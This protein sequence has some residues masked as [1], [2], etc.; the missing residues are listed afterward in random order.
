MTLFDVLS[1][2][3]GWQ[4]PEVMAMRFSNETPSYDGNESMSEASPYEAT[5]SARTSRSVDI[6]SLGCIF[7]CT[8][9]P[10]SHPFGEWYEREANIMKNNPKKK[11]LEWVSPEASD[12]IL[13]MV[14]RDAKCRP[15]AEEVCE[16]PL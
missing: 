2:S 9:L 8:V 11:D 6:F 15:T 7:Y 12:L 10:G 3:V 1:F 13:S 4:A 16:H 14:H 5:I